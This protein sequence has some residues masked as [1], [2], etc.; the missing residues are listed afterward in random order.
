MYAVIATGGKQY[1]VTEGDKIKIE[2]LK[3]GKEGIV[4]DKVLM[5]SDGKETK[6]GSPFIPNAKVDA[7]LIKRGRAKKV[8]I[9]KFRRRK[10]HMKRMGHR[11]SYLEVKILKISGQGVEKKVAEKVVSEE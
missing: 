2:L 8:N 5:I 11:Q 1:R 3:E 4:F 6:V 7:E 10:H 9:L